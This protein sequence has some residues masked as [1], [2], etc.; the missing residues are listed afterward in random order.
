MTELLS[1]LIVEDDPDDILFLTASLKKLQAKD[2]EPNLRITESLNE[3]LEA[4]STGNYDLIITDLY[5]PDSEGVNTFVEI[6]K[7]ANIIPVIIVGGSSEELLIRETIKLGAQDYIPKS[8]LSADLLARTIH[9]AIERHR[10]QE[11]LRALSFTDELTGVYNRRGF[12]TLLDQQLAL[13]R[14]TRKG[15]FLF[16]VDLDHLKQINDTYGHLVGDHALMDMCK[17][18]RATFRKHDIIGRIGGDEFAVIAIN[19]PEESGEYLKNHMVHKL[20]EYN[21]QITEPYRLSYSIGKV[22]YDGLREVDFNQLV[23]IADQ[24]LYEAK[25]AREVP[26]QLE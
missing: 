8:D 10:L 23:E 24:E 6:Q 14:R 13:S 3:A 5:L 21:S 20:Q 15:F 17:C 11:S 16:L 26:S 1:I 18:L 25:R 7:R 22:F 12:L 9:H 19:A 2:I 4:L